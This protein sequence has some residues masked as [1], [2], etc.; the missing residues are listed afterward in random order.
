MPIEGSVARR[1]KISY[2]IF[3]KVVTIFQKVVTKIF[4]GNVY[5]RIIPK[6]LGGL[7]IFSYLCKA[8]K[9]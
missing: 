6:L 2:E 4:N 9:L 8:V 7:G 3:S 1:Q 5:P